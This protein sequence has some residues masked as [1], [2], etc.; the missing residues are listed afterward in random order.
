MRRVWLLGLA[1]LLAGCESQADRQSRREAAALEAE[2]MRYQGLCVEAIARY[3]AI[4][5]PDRHEIPRE[6]NGTGCGGEAL[7]NYSVPERFARTITDSVIRADPSR[8]SGYSIEIR[9]RSGRTYTYVDR[10]V[11]AAA[12]EQKGT[13]DRPPSAPPGAPLPAP[14][15]GG[16]GKAVEPSTPSRE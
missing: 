1:V 15:D 16:A 5:A 3:R 4:Y 10:G 9:S 2:A 12:E 7:R 11:E 13:F 6:L 8:L 14:A